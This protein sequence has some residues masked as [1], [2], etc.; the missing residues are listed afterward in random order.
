MKTPTEKISTVALVI[1]IAAAGAVIYVQTHAVADKAGVLIRESADKLGLLGVPILT[2]LAFRAWNELTR[3]HLPAWRNGLSLSSLVM[4]SASWLS[5]TALRGL[6]SL[7]PSLM[8]SYDPRWVDT[9]LLT[10]LA[11]AVLATSLRGASRVQAFAAALLMWSW[12]ESRIYAAPPG[13]IR[14]LHSALIWAWL[15]ARISV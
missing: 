14:P 13:I 5:Y 12:L 4:I 11:A 1:S 15:H 6:L 8:V 10:T 7:W 9:L 3:P 2:V